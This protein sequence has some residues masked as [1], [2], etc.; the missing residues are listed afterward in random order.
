MTI[1]VAF[2]F[3]GTLADT[4]PALTVLAT[5]LL[6]AFFGMRP[7][8]ARQE[9]LSTIGRPFE[10]QLKI[11]FPFARDT[12]RM[13]DLYNRER[14]KV[15]SIFSGAKPLPYAELVVHTLMTHNIPLFICSSTPFEIFDPFVHKYFLDVFELPFGAVMSKKEQLE[16]IHHAY[17]DAYFVGDA[18]Y[19]HD[20]ADEI[21][22][23]FI[24]ANDG[25]LS[26]LA[27]VL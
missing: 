2:D 10:E 21:G 13:V 3:D 24:S 22:M 23:T 1:A 14:M 26:V 12:K 6:V 9:Y 7:D 17:D 19:D 18:A 11:I 20:L 8:D 4:M 27:T 25:L 5:D 16:H 15:Y